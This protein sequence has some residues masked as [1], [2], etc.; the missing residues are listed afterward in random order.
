MR[1]YCSLFST[2]RRNSRPLIMRDQIR[3]KLNQ[4][5]RRYERLG[6]ATSPIYTEL[7]G[8]VSSDAWLDQ[9]EETCRQ[10]R[11]AEKIFNIV[12]QITAHDNDHRVLTMFAEY[13]TALR[14]TNWGRQFFG[15][16]TDA[17]YLERSNQRQ[18]DF[19]AWIDASVVPVETKMLGEGTGTISGATFVRKFV[20]KVGND[21][22]PQLSRF[23]EDCSFEQGIIFVWT[24]LDI[25]WEDPVNSYQLMKR[26]L[27]MGVD[28]SDIPFGVK[29]IV[30]FNN[31]LGLSDFFLQAGI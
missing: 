25:A 27:E 2:K 17:E 16:F 12:S 14:L 21:A 24:R 7:Q 10:V 26:S 3:D 19:K 23:H 4:I 6:L 20:K 28:M 9:A 30:M 11:S 31:P 5:L 13:D 15:S 29:I 18:P 1:K 22:L 8:F